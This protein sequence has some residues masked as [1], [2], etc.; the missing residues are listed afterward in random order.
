VIPIET[1]NLLRFLR[2]LQLSADEAVLR[3]V[4]RLKLSPKSRVIFVSQESSSDVVQEALRL[5][6]LGYVAKIDASVELLAAVE[7]VC[8]GRQFVSAALVGHVPTELADMQSPKGL[9]PDQLL[10]SETGD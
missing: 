3:T 1:T 6:A 7:A 9:H 2:T 4:A 8:Q 10:A 5:G